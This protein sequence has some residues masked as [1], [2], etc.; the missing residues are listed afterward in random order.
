M[1]VK[2]LRQKAREPVC[3]PWGYHWCHLISWQFW[4]FWRRKVSP[5][6]PPPR[7]RSPGAPGRP[8]RLSS[9]S[10]CDAGDIWGAEAGMFGS[11]GPLSAGGP[12]GLLLKMKYYCGDQV[13]H[14]HLSPVYSLSLLVGVALL[15]CP[16]DSGWRSSRPAEASPS[17]LQ[18]ILY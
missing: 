5:R 13:R 14:L 12:H 9:V 17:R 11:A 15:L 16:P 3:N 1:R 4:E 2:T 18:R 8:G 6:P 7:C 10:S